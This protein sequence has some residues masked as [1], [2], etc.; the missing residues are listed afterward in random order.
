MFLH[1]WPLSLP[2][3]YSAYF[4]K[5]LWIFWTHTLGFLRTL[6]ALFLTIFPRVDARPAGTSLSLW[7][8]SQ[9]RLALHH[10]PVFGYC[11]T[12]GCRLHATTVLALSSLSLVG[13]FWWILTACGDIF[14]L[15]FMF[16]LLSVMPYTNAPIWNRLSDVFPLHRLF[17]NENYPTLNKDKKQ[18]KANNPNLFCYN[19]FFSSCSWSASSVCLE[20]LQQAANSWLCF[21]KN[22]LLICILLK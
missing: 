13:P 19:L 21:K 1:S 22:L 12:F 4:P 18:N 5:C 6:V 3:F 16:L 17:W 20:V 14:F 11:G 2:D 9:E 8:G 10:M 15:H 7:E